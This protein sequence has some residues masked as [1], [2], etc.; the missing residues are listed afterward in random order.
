MKQKSPAAKKKRSLGKKSQRTDLVSEI[1]LEPKDA[2]QISPGQALQFLED[3]RV[4]YSA[5]DEPTRA[6][7]LRVPE[8]LL[9]LLKTRAALEGKK[10]QSLMIEIL[11]KG[12]SDPKN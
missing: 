12:L 9:R 1:N 10:Y 2:G 11:R 5:K 7:S 4:L 6:I 8:N 3:M